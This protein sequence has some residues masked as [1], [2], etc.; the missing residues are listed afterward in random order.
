M[1][2]RPLYYSRKA[3]MKQAQASLKG[4]RDMRVGRPHGAR[5]SSHIL[6]HFT[7][8]LFLQ[9]SLTS[10]KYYTLFRMIALFLSAKYFP[11]SG[12]I[13]REE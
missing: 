6:N 1:G 10:D 3:R 12:Y 8:S 11:A 2:R 7:R 4:K 5:Q 9:L 13:L